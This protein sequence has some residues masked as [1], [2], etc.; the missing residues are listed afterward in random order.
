MSCAP[1]L[2]KQQHCL[3]GE[4]AV[5]DCWIGLSLA[6]DTGLI[7]TGRVG[8]RTDAFLEELV[9]STEGKTDC[10]CWKTDGWKGD[11][12]VLPPDVEHQVGKEGT[13]RLERTN[14]ILPCRQAD[15]IVTRISLPKFGNRPK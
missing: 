12:R 2:K 9:V 13:Q 8:K 3:P 10:Q 1:L 14:G 11:S 4:L 5:G 7:L 6:D 15:G